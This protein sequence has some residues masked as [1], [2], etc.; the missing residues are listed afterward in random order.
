MSG[1]P[2]T[3]RALGGPPPSP[4]WPDVRRLATGRRDFG[5]G[6]APAPESRRHH[7]RHTLE[8]DVSQ[9]RE[10]EDKAQE[11]G[12]KKPGPG[13]DQGNGE[14]SGCMV[15]APVAALL[16]AAAALMIRRR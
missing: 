5:T 13:G 3:G 4:L 9:Y 1:S 8:S 7:P 10:Y 16:L 11:H 15:V 12:H 14:T 2:R 6:Q